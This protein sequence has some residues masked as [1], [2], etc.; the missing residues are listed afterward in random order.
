MVLLAAAQIVLRNLFS[1]SLFWGDD[2]LQLALLWLV[3]GGALVAAR[4]GEHIR[5]NVLVRF[6]PGKIRP[7][8]YAAT[9]AFTA[10]ICLLLT[11][12]S[13]Q[14]VRSSIEYGDTLIGDMPAWIAQLIM[15]IGFGLLAVHFAVRS[16]VQL[17]HGLQRRPAQKVL[18]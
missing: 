14:L 4:N 2:I 6:V 8:V 3:M 12:Q 15:P 10:I 9:H 11:L 16:V 13:I 1:Y 5:I 7:L 18:P 17:F